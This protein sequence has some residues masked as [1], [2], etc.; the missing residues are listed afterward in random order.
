[1]F[2][3]RD[4]MARPEG[5]SNV[6]AA[7]GPGPRGT[8]RASGAG[9]G[10]ARTPRVPGAPCARACLRLGDR[11]AA[12]R[13]R[14][15][16][17][18]PHDTPREYAGIALRPPR[19]R[20]IVPEPEAPG[21]RGRPPQ[22]RPAAVLGTVAAGPVPRCT[23]LGSRSAVGAT[24]RSPVNQEPDRTNGREAGLARGPRRAAGFPVARQL[25]DLAARHL[26]RR[27]GR[28]AVPD[29][30]SQRVR[31][32][33]A[34]DA[35]PLPD[36]PDAGA[37]RRLQ[38]PGRVRRRRPPARPRRRPRPWRAQ[39]VRV[40]PTRVGRARGGGRRGDLPQRPL[41]L[42][43]LHRRLGQPA[44]PRGVAVGRGAPRATPTTRCSCTAA[45]ASARR[46]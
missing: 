19:G 16:P 29:R 10:V 38:R 20:C 42:L 24:H 1:M 39:P 21:R 36:L 12:G 9:L 23:L 6:S 8:A 27:R 3:G 44:R 18:L 35:L 14:R 25:R 33:L 26:P 28:P 31:E 15:V 41:H 37:R 2:V 7:R 34:R 43:E 45:S 32:G 11:T 5:V 46:T 22:R 4:D 40:E 13:P 30:R 17:R